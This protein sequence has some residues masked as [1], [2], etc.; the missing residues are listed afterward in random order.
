M[1]TKIA[2]IL[3]CCFIVGCDIY[4]LAKGVGE[5]TR[6]ACAFVPD[7][8]DNNLKVLIEKQDGKLGTAEVIQVVAKLICAAVDAE[9]AKARAPGRMLGP[10]VVQGLPISGK[11]EP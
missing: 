1:K 2:V 11:Y 9:K 5:A 3:S 4:S 7:A 6:L 10:I 8:T